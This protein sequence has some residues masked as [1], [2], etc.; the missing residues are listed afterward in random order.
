MNNALL[1]NADISADLKEAID[2]NK[3]TYLHRSYQIFEDNDIWKNW[4]TK[5]DP[6]RSRESLRPAQ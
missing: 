3:G 1:A 5:A 6:R 2:K 4:I